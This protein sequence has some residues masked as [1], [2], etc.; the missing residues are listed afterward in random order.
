MTG[1]N[2]FWRGLRHRE[3]DRVD[4]AKDRRL[5]PRHRRGLACADERPR[6]QHHRERSEAAVVGHKVGGDEILQRETR[7]ALAGRLAGVDRAAHL[8]AHLREVDLQ[9]V[10][11]DS[12]RDANGDRLAAIHAVVVEQRLRRV[13]AARKAPQ[14][15]AHDALGLVPADLDRAFDGGR[16]I[17]RIE[18]LQTALAQPARGDLRAQVAEAGLRLA[19]IVAQD[20]EQFLVR[21]A[22]LV[23]L[24][25][26]H[27]DAFLE[28]RH[29]VGQE[30]AREASAHVGP[31]RARGREADQLAVVERWRVDDHIVEMLAAGPGMVGDNHVARLEAPGAE[32]RQAVADRRVEITDENRQAARRLRD[33]PPLRVED[34]RAEVLHLV[35]DGA[36]RRAREVDGHF[37]GVGRERVVDYADGDRI[38]SGVHARVAPLSCQ[39]SRRG[40]RRGRAPPHRRDA[41]RWWRRTPR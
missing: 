6:R 35:D 10:A 24:D 18:F 23:E 19:D 1:G 39:S 13:D 16:A 34:C 9:A 26:A 30:T 28:A 38:D 17:A 8:C 14:P 21:L 40:S 31:V 25:R 4:H 11:F 37:L 41:R 22:A 29:R 7:C 20:A 32:E 33:Q 5:P 2:A 12:H 27:L 36:V 15:V 3:Q